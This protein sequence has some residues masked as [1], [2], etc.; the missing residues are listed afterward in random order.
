MGLLGTGHVT[1]EEPR[2]NDGVDHDLNDSVALT[3]PAAPEFL[4]LVRLHVGAVGARIDMTVEEIEDLH[5]AVEE[6]CLSLLSPNGGSDGRLVVDVGWDAT[7]LEVTCTLVGG[8]GADRPIGSSALPG[9]LSKRI[10]DALVDEHG[11]S[12]DGGAPTVWLRKRRRQ[13]SAAR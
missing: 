6:L 2:D 5:L 9:D 10:L 12:L 7:S 1:A 11:S 3:I 8:D 4:Q 13:G